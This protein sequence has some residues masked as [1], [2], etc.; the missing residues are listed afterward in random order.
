MHTWLAG[1]AV[2]L[3]GC[4]ASNDLTIEDAAFTRADPAGESNSGHTV[5]G[6][7]SDDGS[8]WDD[9]TAHITLV[10]QG[11]ISTVTMQIQGA[12]PDTLF[13]SWLRLRGTD[14]ETGE[15]YGGN[16]INGAGSTPLAHSDDL[17][18]LGMMAPTEGETEAPNAGW[19]DADGNGSLVVETDFEVYGGSYPFD[20]YHPAFEPVPT[21]TAPDGPFLVRLAS[22]CTDG[23]AHGLRGGDRETWF[24]WSP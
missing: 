13:T 12:R 19:T 16:P 5:V 18:M 7:C 23:L 15:D 4:S 14:P 8:T 24:N 9:A 1:F 22:H 6:D 2:L 20:K 3:S 21:V 11:G 17:G 10:Q